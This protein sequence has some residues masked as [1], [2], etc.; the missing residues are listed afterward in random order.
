MMNEFKINPFVLPCAAKPWRRRKCFALAKC[1]NGY[2]TLTN[3]IVF[4]RPACAAK[5]RR[6]VKKMT[7]L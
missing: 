1:I 3:F 7:Y 4:F 6:D 5:W 2:R